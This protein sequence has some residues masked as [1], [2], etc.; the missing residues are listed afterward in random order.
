[1][2][3]KKECI[4]GNK[5]KPAPAG[6]GTPVKKLGYFLFFESI[7]TLNLAKRRQ[8]KTIK[9]SIAIQAVIPLSCRI[10]I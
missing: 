8:D 1:L 7:S 9:V 5:T 6:V 10:E 4:R 3:P 2:N